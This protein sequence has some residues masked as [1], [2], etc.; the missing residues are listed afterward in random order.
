ME[1]I[2]QHLWM[3]HLNQVEHGIDPEMPDLIARKKVDFAPPRDLKPRSRFSNNDM[4]L[5]IAELTRLIK[6]GINNREEIFR[7]VKE[8][9]LLPGPEENPMS[10]YTVFDHI[11]RLRVQLEIPAKKKFEIV[12]EMYKDGLSISEICKGLNMTRKNV[13]A[14]LVNHGFIGKSEPTRSYP[15]NERQKTTS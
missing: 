15:K 5:F 13:H 8:N 7:Q 2:T 4:K 10:C 11:N 6:L 14:L 9:G 1:N 3:V 12:I